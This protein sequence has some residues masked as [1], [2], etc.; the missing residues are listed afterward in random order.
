MAADLKGVVA[1][2]DLVGPDGAD[3]DDGAEDSRVRAR[4]DPVLDGDLLEQLVLVEC[5]VGIKILR[6]HGTKF[7]VQN[8]A[9]CGTL[10]LLVNNV[11]GVDCRRNMCICQQSCEYGSET[12][13]A[14]R[15]RTKK[16]P[17]QAPMSNRTFLTYKSVSVLKSFFLKD[18]E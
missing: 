8:Q 11:R 5:I 1:G 14:G 12:L 15:I 4:Q 2:R 7:T 16:A 18:V 6:S 10:P 3:P 9:R 17:D 13:N